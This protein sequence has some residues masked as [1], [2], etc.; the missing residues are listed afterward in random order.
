MKKSGNIF[1][2]LEGNWMKSIGKYENISRGTIEFPVEYYT[3]SKSSVNYVMKYHWHM[4]WEFIR[5]NKGNMTLTLNENSMLIKSGDVVI[6]PGGI[7]HGAEPYECEY[8]CIVMHSSV[9]FNSGIFA[10]NIIRSNIK[11]ALIL[12]RDNNK[13]LCDY[14]D[15]FFDALKNRINGFEITAIGSVNLLIGKIIERN[16]QG[17][18][19][20]EKE[21]SNKRIDNIKEALRVIE[22]EFGSDISLEK[23]AKSCGMS[24]RYFCEFFKEMTGYTPIDYLNRYRIETACKLLTVS[25]MNVTETAL[26]CGFNDISYFIKIFKKYVGITPKQFAIK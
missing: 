15:L 10:K 4:D 9:I 16:I 22:N 2:Y 3:L 21:I 14:A 5:I 8:D 12:N 25:R 1:G 20:T 24:A 17:V 19:G 26:S 18:S 7:L 11:S 6:I 13:I 23:L